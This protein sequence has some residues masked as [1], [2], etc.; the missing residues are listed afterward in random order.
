V[1]RRELGGLVWAYIGPLP[2][3]EPPRFDVFVMD[4]VRDIGWTELPCNFV[5]IMENA[6]DPHHTE[7]LH[8]R[9]FEFMGPVGRPCWTS[10]ALRSWP[11]RRKIADNRTPGGEP[12]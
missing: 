4:G 1:S 2:A 9:F 10:Q 11:C 12:G 3:P 7:W 5:Q 8:S 6:V